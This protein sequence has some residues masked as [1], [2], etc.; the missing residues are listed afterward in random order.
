VLRP[1][2]LAGRRIETWDEVITAIA[3]A[4]DYSN[5]YR[6]SFAWGQRRRHRPR[7]QPSIVLLPRAALIAG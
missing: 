1:L 4:T 7:R 2:A 6:H 3:Q 5:A